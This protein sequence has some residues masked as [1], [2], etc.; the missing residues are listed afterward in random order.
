MNL[1]EEVKGYLTDILPIRDKIHSNPELSFEEHN[2]T[3]TIKDFLL[4]LGIEVIDIGIKTGVVGV[5]RCKS[6][7]SKTVALRADIDAIATDNGAMHLC[8]HD[9]H[10]S[11]LLCCAKYA[12]QNIDRLKNNAIFIFQPAEETTTGAKY[13]INNGLW[14]KFPFAPDMI[15]GIHNR[16]EMADGTVRVQSGPLMSSKSDFTITVK[17][18]T[19]HSGSPHQC[20]DPI[21]A[22]ASIVQAVQTIIS[23]NTDPFQPCVC[24]I[25]SIHGG[26]PA[27]FAPESV[28]MTG[29]IRSLDRDAHINC[30]RRLREIVI[31][32]CNAYA[33]TCDIDIV[34]LVPVLNNTELMTEK[35][36][37]I[38]QNAVSDDKIVTTTPCMGSEDFSVYGEHIPYYFYWIGSGKAGCDNAPWHSADFSIGEEFLP[39]A[40]SIFVSALMT[41]LN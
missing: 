20:I 3:K 33:C 31:N 5:L 18:K 4:N 25:C 23:R 11:A 15:F 19:G 13:L 40:S 12:S 26:S 7:N 2:T 22:S 29:S 30:E 6:K 27:N 8:G 35:A 37:K 28:T 17:G 24:A 32:T 41:E 36:L 9:Y 34:S 16:P 10:T 38:A 14:D 39:T 21:T 1:Y